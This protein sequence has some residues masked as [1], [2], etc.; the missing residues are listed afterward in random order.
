MWY[1]FKSFDFLHAVAGTFSSSLDHGLT[2]IEVLLYRKIIRLFSL[3]S[4]C[5]GSCRQDVYIYIT[6]IFGGLQGTV[7]GR[8]EY[9]GVGWWIHLKSVKKTFLTKVF[10]V[11]STFSSFFLQFFSSFLQ[12]ISS[13]PIFAHQGVDPRFSPGSGRE[14]TLQDIMLIESSNTEAEIL[15]QYRF[16]VNGNITKSNVIKLI[17]AQLRVT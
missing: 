4:L 8:A 17:V 2:W 3:Y 9:S 6:E 15:S 7:L 13:F 16:V 1:F 11:F 10:Q 5:R 12:F 14:F